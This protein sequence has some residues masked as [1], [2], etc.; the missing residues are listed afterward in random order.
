MGEILERF[1]DRETFEKYWKDHYQPVDYEQVREQYEEFVRGADKKIFLNDY[2]E[3]NLISRE[4]FWKNL[5][6]TAEFAF[7][8]ALTEAFYEKN[9]ELYELAFGIYE[10]EQA[11]E[12]NGDNVA[13]IF[14][15]E[16]QRL[17]RSFLD[18]MF[19]HIYGRS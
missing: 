11:G 5:S 2:E 12:G 19:D 4:D 6:Q 13:R 18:Q 17:Y 7:Q 14:H 10:E 8:D 9:P 3:K 15:E 1:P 16:Y